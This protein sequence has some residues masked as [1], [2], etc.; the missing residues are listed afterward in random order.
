MLTVT[1]QLYLLY[2]YTKDLNFGLQNTDF[3]MKELITDFIEFADEESDMI[4]KVDGCPLFRE[5]SNTGILLKERT[6]S[7]E[8]NEISVK[9]FFSRSSFRMTRL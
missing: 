6:T 3:G 1:F 9:R 2:I 7:S 8:V 4:Y 5:E